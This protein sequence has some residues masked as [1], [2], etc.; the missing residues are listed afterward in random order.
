LRASPYISEAIV[1]GDGMKY[2][3][4]LIEIEFDAVSDWAIRQ[5]IA[6]TGFASLTTN[7]I[8][9][10]LIEAEVAAAN[11]NLAR[12]EQIKA[13]RIIPKV[14][15]PEEEGEPI[16]PTR[17]VKRKFMFEK[18]ADLIDSMYGHDEETRL[19]AAIGTVF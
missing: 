10:K 9:V 14:L 5:N 12:V 4:A 8:V 15:D 13:F 6:F 11:G 18:F 16:T 3:T 17:K 1:Y 7:P 19:N 2:L